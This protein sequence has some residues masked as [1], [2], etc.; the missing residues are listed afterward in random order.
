LQLEG[1]IYGVGEVIFTQYAKSNFVVQDK[2]T[3]GLRI[4]VMQ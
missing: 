4:L 1:K 3:I 2:G